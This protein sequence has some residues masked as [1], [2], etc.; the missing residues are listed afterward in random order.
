M[1]QYVGLQCDGWIEQARGGFCRS[2]QSCNWLGAV[3]SRYGARFEF[4]VEPVNVTVLVHG[5][6]ARLNLFE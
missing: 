1:I 4:L 5:L 3:Y 2:H 6:K